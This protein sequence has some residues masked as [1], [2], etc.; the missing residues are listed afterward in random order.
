M[1]IE[2]AN[3]RDA[4]V[5]ASLERWIAVNSEST[6]FHRPAWLMAVERGTGQ[7]AVM[8]VARDEC[9][10]ITGVLPLTLIK[11][12]LFGNAIISSAFAVGGGMLCGSS[13]T[14]KALIE[15]L[16]LL[17]NGKGCSTAELRGGVLPVSDWHL[18]SDLYL[19]FCKPL[20]R[21]DEKQLLAVPKRHRAE[22]RKGL[23][24]GLVFEVG[25]SEKFRKIHYR[26]YAQNV[27]RLGT[28]VFPRR[29]FERVLDE[30]GDDADVAIVSRNEE[31]ISAVLTLYHKHVAMPYWHGASDKARGSH[32]NEVLYFRLMAHAR[33]LGMTHFDFGRSKTGTGPAAWKKSWGWEGVP[34][35]YAARAYRGKK[36]RDIN[37]LSPKYQRKIGLWKKLPLP[38]AN[39]IGPILARGL[40]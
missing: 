14:Q 29:L 18:S 33:S 35:C 15:A 9:G 23:S 40:G 39:L 37:P 31:P 4:A 20:E 36:L 25:R 11:S 16:N 7:S 5:V 22:L 1:P 2:C 6:P 12:R 28:P 34:L 38:V 10:S 19:D 13:D 8:L 26:L 3:L 24:N 27:H 21:D 17:A 30:F 32:S